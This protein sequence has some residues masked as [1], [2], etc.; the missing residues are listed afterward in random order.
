MSITK[1]YFINFFTASRKRKSRL[2]TERYN[3]TGE[4]KS[5]NATKVR[6]L[7]IVDSSKSEEREVVDGDE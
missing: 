5:R 7:F 4:L 3:F 2:K 6:R 1:S